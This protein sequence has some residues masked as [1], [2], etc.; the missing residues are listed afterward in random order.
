MSSSLYTSA[1]RNWGWLLFSTLQIAL[2]TSSRGWS[3]FSGALLLR[4]PAAWAGS[5]SS[6]GHEHWELGFHLREEKY[7]LQT[8]N[9][10]QTFMDSP[11]LAWCYVK[12]AK[13]NE[14]TVPG[15]DTLVVRKSMDFS[16]KGC[17][18]LE[19]LAQPVLIRH[20]HTNIYTSNAW[21]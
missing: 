20:V 14:L 8:H 15:A 4:P 18:I 1:K 5:T 3:G 12:A 16:N 11:C 13:E 7:I 10:R 9:Y 21:I 19:P 17:N 6:R 2:V